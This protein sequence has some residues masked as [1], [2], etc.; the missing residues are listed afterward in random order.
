MGLIWVLVTEMVGL[1]IGLLGVLANRSV[2]REIGL[3]CWLVLK[4]C[5]LEEKILLV[6]STGN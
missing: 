5:C 2:L 6:L 3:C 4:K 1:E